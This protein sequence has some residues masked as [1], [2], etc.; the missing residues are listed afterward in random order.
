MEN[1]C[2]LA[3]HYSDETVLYQ[4]TCLWHLLS[5]HVFP[6]CTSSLSSCI[7]HC[8]VA[9]PMTI[10]KILLI[11]QCQV[12]LT[13]ISNHP[14]AYI[15]LRHYYPFCCPFLGEEYVKLLLFTPVPAIG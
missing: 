12:F 4:S 2:K 3:F 11:L 8:T 14:I 5:T 10:Y 1:E 6:A 9:D 13:Q 15:L 7:S